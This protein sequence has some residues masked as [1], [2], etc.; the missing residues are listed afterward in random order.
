MWVFGCHHWMSYQPRRHHRTSRAKGEELSY[1]RRSSACGSRCRG[2]ALTHTLGGNRATTSCSTRHQAAVVAPAK[3][4]APFC[5]RG[6]K[7][8]LDDDADERW[9]MNGIMLGPTQNLEMTFLLCRS[10]GVST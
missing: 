7:D 8:G 5:W 3:G 10:W 2:V 6:R 9:A 4:E 1:D